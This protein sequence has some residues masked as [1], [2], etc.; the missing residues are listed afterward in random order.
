MIHQ[1]GVLR[2]EASQAQMF[3]LH[4]GNV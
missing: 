3:P 2:I 1:L 4:L